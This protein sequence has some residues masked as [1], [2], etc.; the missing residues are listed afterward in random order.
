MAPRRRARILGSRSTKAGAFSAASVANDSSTDGDDLVKRKLT[1]LSV[2]AAVALLAIGTTAMANHS[3]TQKHY[4]AKLQAREEVPS[5]KDTSVRAGG[6]FTAT[7]DGS[8]LSWKLEFRHLTGSATA[9]HIHLGKKGKAGPV[10][11]PL[12]GP[13]S[14]GATGSV[15]V[16]SKVASQLDHNQAYVNVHTAKNPGGEIRGQLGR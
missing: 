16:S 8:S 9:A 15:K 10:I 11:V 13:C 1:F 12:C 2:T 7:L 5:P 14:S 6:K 3:K 4:K